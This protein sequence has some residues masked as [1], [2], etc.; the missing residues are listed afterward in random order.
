M[1]DFNK[2]SNYTEESSFS[3]VVFGS[4]RP[5]LEVELNEVQQ[6][7][8]SKFN[9][10]MKA[11]GVNILFL[12]DPVYSEGVLT[13][14]SALIFEEKGGYIFEVKEAS[15]E[16][17]ENDEIY[18]QIEEKVV[19]SSTELHS[20]GNST[21]DIIANH[22]RDDRYPTETTKRKCVTYTLMADSEV[23]NNTDTIK[24]IGVAKIE[25]ED[26]VYSDSSITESLLAQI[27]NTQRAVVSAIDE[28][29]NKILNIKQKTIT[30][31]TDANGNAVTNMSSDSHIV[32]V[33]SDT[34]MDG[35]CLTFIPCVAN[36]F[37]Y[38]RI[39]QNTATY[40]PLVNSEITLTVTYLE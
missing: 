22:I 34:Y 10:V 25:G 36:N 28:V 9:K 3:S 26:I 20:Y 4:N 19:D 35:D 14:D 1:S 21:S 11:L 16:C 39:L 18:L 31:S 33:K 32:N 8:N 2:Y 38:V 24:Y 40:T 30:V 27:K 23:P 12:S 13:I 37:W 6:I 7:I 17:N 5:L 29:N 15:V